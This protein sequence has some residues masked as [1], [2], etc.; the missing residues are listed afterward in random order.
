MEASGR[1][2]AVFFV[3]TFS[4]ST[5]LICRFYAKDQSGEIYRSH[6]NME[7]N[8]ELSYTHDSTNHNKIK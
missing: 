5:E 4:K 6:N 7:L 2:F 3:A 1:S 8:A